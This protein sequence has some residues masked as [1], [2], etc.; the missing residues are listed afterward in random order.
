MTNR[1]KVNCLFK[2]YSDLNSFIFVSIVSL[3]GTLIL[4]YLL[5]ITFN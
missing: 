2:F 4:C 1:F 5:N 3:P